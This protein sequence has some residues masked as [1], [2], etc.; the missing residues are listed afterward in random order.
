MPMPIWLEFVGAC[1]Q[2]YIYIYLQASLFNNVAHGGFLL[3]GLTELK[4]D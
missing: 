3:D 1:L 4:F 2:I